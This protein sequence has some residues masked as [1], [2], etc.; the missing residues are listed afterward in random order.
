MEKISF[1]SI[2]SFTRTSSYRVF[3]AWRYL[4]QHMDDW[5]NQADGTA[6]LDMNPDFQRGHVWTPEQQTA[7]LEY[8]IKGGMS[9]R[10]LYFNCRG[11]MGKWDGPF[12]I[13]D[14]KQRLTAALGFLKGEIPAFGRYYPKDFTDK[15]HSDIGFYFNVND[16]K[17]RKEVLQWYLEMNAG[18]TPHSP[19]EIHKVEALLTKEK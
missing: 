15:P 16:L 5:E 9:G 14:G 3:V 2:P 12:V 8:A 7:Y 11:W 4:L 6:V 13:V 1:L 17:T 10:D 19:E 18:G